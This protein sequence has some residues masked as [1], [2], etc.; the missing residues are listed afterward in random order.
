[1]VIFFL[2]F[3]NHKWNQRQWLKLTT[4]THVKWKMEPNWGLIT[5]QVQPQS[6]SDVPIG[7]L[8]LCKSQQSERPVNYSSV[9]RTAART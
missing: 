3:T 1:M 7:I 9:L 5:R 4:I 6:F 8:T 2:C